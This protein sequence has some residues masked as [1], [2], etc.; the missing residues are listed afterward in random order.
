MPN[1]RLTEDEVITLEAAV[2]P[3][4]QNY[5]VLVADSNMNFSAQQLNSI[6]DSVEGYST[7]MEQE[8]N[9]ANNHGEMAGFQAEV[10]NCVSI[11][12][13]V[14]TALAAPV[15]GVGGKRRKTRK[16][17]KTR[18]GRRSGKS[19]KNLRRK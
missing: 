6:K 11:L 14:D 10:D 7:N 15:A 4:P 3:W 17:R 2:S 12:E 18:K 16:A 8:V 1:L 9:A 19:R 5:P 13:K